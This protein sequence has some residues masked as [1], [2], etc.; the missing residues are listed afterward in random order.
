MRALITF[1]LGVLSVTTSFTA[2]K[3]NRKING[4]PCPVVDHY[5]TRSCKAYWDCTAQL[6]LEK[7]AIDAQW[8]TYNISRSSLEDLDINQIG[9]TPMWLRI[10]DGK[11]FCVRHPHL[12]RNKVK[13]RMK[14]YR[15]LHYINRINRI[16]IKGTN[17]IPHGTEWWTQHSDLAKMP[18][19]NT[20]PP[21]FS[22]SSSSDFADIAGIPFMSFS[23]KKAM[24]ENLVRQDNKLSSHDSWE[25][26]KGTAFFRGALSDCQLS[27]QKYNG[28][29]NYCARAKI[30]YEAVRTKSKLLEEVRTTSSFL[31]TG[32]NI[33]CPSCTRGNLNGEDFMKNLWDHKYL[34]N[35]DG[36]GK[37]SRRLS[38][39][40]RT[41]GLIFHAQSSGYQFYDFQLKPGRHYIPF[42]PDVGSPGF[43]NLLSRIHWAEGNPNIA[44][45]IAAR[46]ESFGSNCL[47]EESIDYFVSILLQQYSKLLSGSSSE[48]PLVDLS[49]CF[50]RDRQAHISRLCP[51]VIRN[52]WN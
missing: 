7:W 45:K 15:A 3:A 16:L 24:S 13:L 44:R 41:G 10:V 11:L 30:V 22:V 37:W 32:L 8:T 43:G 6:L 9:H 4:S 23:D 18:R 39:L 19:R 34:L 35:F 50:S 48:L 52:C 5:T 14:M 47:K 17:S 25:S 36:A 40:L 31:K 51:K 38:L 49:T 21:V 28:D 33:D 46:T 29:V 12:R 2:V 42:D 26:R 27:I 20:L 1:Y